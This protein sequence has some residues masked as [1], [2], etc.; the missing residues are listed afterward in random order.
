MSEI[1]T[2][3]AWASHFQTHFLAAIALKPTWT[4]AEIN[5]QFAAS[6]A[7]TAAWAEAA[8]LMP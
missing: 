6:L 2:A 7:A 8:G 1:M 3:E 5:A 4:V